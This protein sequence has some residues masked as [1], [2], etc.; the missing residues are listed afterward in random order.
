MNFLPLALKKLTVISVHTSEKQNKV[1]IRGIRAGRLYGEKEID[2]T[3]LDNYDFQQEIHNGFW[4]NCAPR[5]AKKVFASYLRTLCAEAEELEV[6]TAERLGF[7]DTGVHRGYITGDRC[8]GNSEMLIRI[9]DELKEYR[10]MPKRYDSAYVSGEI[11]AYLKDL[12]GLNQR[13]VPI[14]LAGDVIAIT[15]SLF[16]KAGYPI[17]FSLYARGEQSTGKTTTVTH[18]CSMFRRDEDIEAT[19]HNLTATEAKLHKVLDREADRAV[20]IDDLR[21]SD[22]PSNIKHQE[23]VLDSLIRVAANKVGRETML[24]EREVRGFC[25]FI[26]EYALKTPSTNNRIVLLNFEK[27]DLNKEQL[28]KVMREPE[29]LGLF[30]VWFIEWVLEHYDEIVHNIRQLCQ[31]Y[32]KRRSAEKAYQE[33][34][35]SHGNAL[36]IAYNLLLEFCDEK[37]WDLGWTADDFNISLQNIIS[38]QIECLEL[39]DVQRTDVLVELYYQVHQ[40]LDYQDNV[41]LHPSK[42]NW[43]QSLYLDE[44]KRLLYIP[45]PTV[46]KMLRRA[47]I[48]MDV[49]DAMNDFYIA[50]LLNVDKSKNGSRTKKIAG[51][52]CYVISY[53]LWEDYARNI[54]E[55]E[56]D[57]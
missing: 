41:C 18:A 13:L 10:M 12:I 31:M 24:Y 43:N 15:S 25:I 49:P 2:I 21:M 28:I 27:Q 56:A 54:I 35:M 19:L 51:K 1:V 23:K 30:F 11:E 29:R 8:I 16:A 34:L 14:L 55:S 32:F 40:E 57:E 48:R 4:V 6:Y 5:G 53:D 47:G 44:H 38:E 50:G 37:K 52:R 46:E 7:F 20:I 9:S 26:G 33:R 42:T 22:S 17:R 39:G 36:M 3:A 45:S